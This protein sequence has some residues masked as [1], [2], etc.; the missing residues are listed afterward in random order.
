MIVEGWSTENSVYYIELTS[1]CSWNHY[2]VVR[3]SRVF[4]QHRASMQWSTL[5]IDCVCDIS[6]PFS[7]MSPSV[8]SAFIWSCDYC[9]DPFL[10]CMFCLTLLSFSPNLSFSSFSPRLLSLGTT[11]A[12]EEIQNALLRL[13]RLLHRSRYSYRTRSTEYWTARQGSC[14]DHTGR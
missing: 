2:A 14:W 11:S 1:Y 5:I 8:R 7:L 6:H 13:F 3:H 4:E 10:P 12:R 9:E